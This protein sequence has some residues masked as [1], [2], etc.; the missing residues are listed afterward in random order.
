MDLR[1]PFSKPCRGGVVPEDNLKTV[2]MDQGMAIL[3]THLI[4][5]VV[6]R[7]NAGRVFSRGSV[8]LVPPVSIPGPSIP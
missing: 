6:D 4:F 5:E 8:R 3:R 7:S 2:D 1:Q